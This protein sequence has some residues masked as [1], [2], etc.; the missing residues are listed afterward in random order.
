MVTDMSQQENWDRLHR[1]EGDLDVLKPQVAGLQTDVA[2]IRQSIDA[3]VRANERAFPWG[4][5]VSLVSVVVIV[6][7]GF[8]TMLT[9]P[10]DAMTKLNRADLAANSL[11]DHKSAIELARI[12]GYVDAL[13]EQVKQIDE[14]GSRKWNDERPR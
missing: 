6:V 1:V 12:Q 4:A 13:A 14:H 2:Y 5:M 3:L 9:T 8:A 10:I 11:E 7:G